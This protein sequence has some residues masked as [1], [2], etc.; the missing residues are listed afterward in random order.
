MTRIGDSARAFVYSLF[1]C[2]TLV[3]AADARAFVHIVKSGESLAQI[4]ERTY[5][6]ASRETVLVGANALDAQGGS[7][8]RPGM[9]LD[10]PAPAHFRAEGGETWGE[11]ADSFLGDSKR[12][13]VLARYNQANAWTPVAPGQ[14]VAIPYVLTHTAAEG[15]FLSGIAKR[16]L[17]DANQSWQLDT[18]NNL[19]GES[20]H[21]GDLVLVP[22]IDLSLTEEGRA[23]AARGIDRERSEGYGAHLDAQ[24]RAEGEIPLLIADIRGGR[25][26]DAVA[27]GNRILGSGDLTGPQL[28]RV[29]RALL[30]AYVALDAQGAAAG[31]CKA[32]RAREVGATLDPMRVSPKIRSACDD[33]VLLK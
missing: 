13:D 22:L 9:R 8:L 11:L 16:Y 5:G 20:L 1:M 21:R 3:V 28:A 24:R 17:K 6:D 7:V 31:A 19:K 27:R 25:Y 33:A 32:W 14:E 29:H 12:A 10:V 23:E 30:E 15:D 2:A 4:A 26:V 18:Y